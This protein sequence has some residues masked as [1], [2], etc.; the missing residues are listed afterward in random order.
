MAILADDVALAMA[1]FLVLA[2]FVMAIALLWL[3]ATLGRRGRD[4]P[5][6]PPR[7]RS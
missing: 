6:V 3:V 2:M 7:G 4:E 1:G 5:A